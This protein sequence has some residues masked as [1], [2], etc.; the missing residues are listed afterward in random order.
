MGA[1]LSQ[2]ICDRV[3]KLPQSH[4]AVYPNLPK[5]PTLER[6][7]YQ[8]LSLLPQML[9]LDRASPE[10]LTRIRELLLEVVKD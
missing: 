10:D 4:L 1:T 2:E 8:K 7:F 5:F 3:K 9:E 6:T